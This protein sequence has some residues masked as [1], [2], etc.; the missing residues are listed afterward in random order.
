MPP[1]RPRAPCRA[2]WRFEAQRSTRTESL[3]AWPDRLVPAARKVSGVPSCAQQASTRQ[4]SVSVST[5]T[6]SF[7]SS[8]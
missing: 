3:I 5:T 1:F 4:T 8:R 6:T 7:G 2:R